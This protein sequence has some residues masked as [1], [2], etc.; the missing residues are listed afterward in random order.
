MGQNGERRTK[1]QGGWHGGEMMNYP[2]K[3]M[4]DSNHSV[5]SGSNQAGLGP[6]TA[7]K[8]NNLIEK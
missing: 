8:A 2:V 1:K 4:E 5:S 7:Y 3:S 6:H